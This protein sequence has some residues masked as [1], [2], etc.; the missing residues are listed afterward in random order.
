MVLF[1]ATEARFIKNK[2]GIVYAVD[3]SFSYDLWKRY[4]GS[5]SE[6]HVIARVNFESNFEDNKNTISSGNNV[7]FKE[8]PY[9][10][11]WF[12]FIKKYYSFKSSVK[13][14]VYESEGVFICRVPGVVGTS[15]IKRLIKLNKKFGLEVVGDPWEV[16]ETGKFKIPFKTLIKYKLYFDLKNQIK[17]ASAVLYVTKETLQKRY[18]PSENQFTT[19][20]SDVKIN[21]R[22]SNKDKNNSLIN[23]QFV[24]YVSN[25]KLINRDIDF[26]K[27]IPTNSNFKI[28]S[29]GSLAQLY[30][31][32]DVL[33]KAVSILKQRGINCKLTWLGDGKFLDEIKKLSINCGV[34]NNVEFIGNV[35]SETVFQYL[36]NSDL[37]VLASRTEGLPRAIVEAMSVGMPC[38]ATR[39]GGIPEL[40]E[41]S[42]LVE[43]DDEISLA[44][45]IQYLFENPDF[46]NYQA[47]RNYEE[48]KNYLEDVLNLK[49]R[50]FFEF[51]I[52]QHSL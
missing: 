21:N 3:K 6:I 33:I 35:P 34:Y 27:K 52:K 40:L 45:K 28:I 32:P 44:N 46:F 49:R 12:G 13:K 2:Q 47:K 42:V 38:V 31:G 9:Y 16:I 20:I 17:N 1:F 8:I 39:V 11:G 25:V 26:I 29:V 24:T 18:P 50:A 19:N 23:D 43:K 7:F 10:I 51:L 15:V 36:E 5:F 30:K 37:F 14:I 48:S 4:L 41:E 22:D